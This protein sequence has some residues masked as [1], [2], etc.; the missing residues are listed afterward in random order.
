MGVS[1]NQKFQLRETK[2]IF[3]QPETWVTLHSGHI[4]YTFPRVIDLVEVQAKEEGR[5]EVGADRAGRG[6]SG[7]GVRALREVEEVVMVGC[8]YG[9]E[10]LPQP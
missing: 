9:G 3:V 5:Q 7:R 10:S 4:G 8:P 2:E 1:R 6:R